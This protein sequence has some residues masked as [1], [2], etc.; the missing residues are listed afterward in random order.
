MIVER[1][2]TVPMSH[3]AAPDALAALERE[4]ARIHAAYVRRHAW[5]ADSDAYAPWNP[6]SILATSQRKRLAAWM[7]HDAGVFPKHGDQCLEIGA[8]IRGWLGELLD[9]GLREEDLHAID[10]DGARIA[11][12]RLA[13]PAVDFRVGDAGALPWPDG[14]FGMVIASTVFTS[15]LDP[16][17]RQLVAAEA[18]RVLRRG[19]CLVWYDFAVDNPR[20]RDVRKVSR[21]E[22]AAL[23]PD[24]NGRIRSCTLAPPLAR[25]V[26][27]SRAWSWP[28]ATLLEAVPFLRTHL[29]AVLI[30]R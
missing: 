11:A 16:R 6:A 28:L 10:L 17:V 19:G 8:G 3:R 5:E 12:G 29:I 15:I 24:L 18:T 23:F 13:L 30:K 7:L 26:A 4:E 2:T 9:W 25:L 22:L 20:N 21:R 14:T 1:E 27:S